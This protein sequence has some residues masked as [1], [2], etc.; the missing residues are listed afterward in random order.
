MRRCGVDAL[1]ATSPVHITYFTDYCCWLDCWFK[2]YMVSPG[3]SSHLT[4]MFA[5]LPLEGESA[6]ILN[7]IFA[8]NASDIWVQD[9]QTFGDT[10]L[11]FSAAAAVRDAEGLRIAG[12]LQSA[13][14]FR[15]AAD[16]LVSTLRSRQLSNAVIGVELEGMRETTLAALRTAFPGAEFR[17]CSNLLR[18]IRMVKSP[19][20][21]LR[22]TRAAEISESASLEAFSMA[23]PGR[24]MSEIAL[25]YRKR[26]AEMGAKEDHFTFSPRG[27]GIAAEPGYTFYGDDTMYMDFGCIYE[28][29]F[30]DT[31][32]TLAL[33]PMPRELR[34]RY[35]ALRASIEAG[36]LELRPGELSSVVRSAM[37]TA[38][39]AHGFDAAF[40]HGHGLGLE[41]REYP[42]LV[43]DN[44]LR[45]QDGCI[46]LPSDLPLE[47]GMVINLEAGMFVP[48]RG[49]LQIE[50]TFVVE[51]ASSRP[52][53]PQLR[54]AAYGHHSLHWGDC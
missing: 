36:V 11:D 12:R 52:L 28:H 10:G 45:V 14:K 43:D 53:I 40:P 38:F 20:E 39:R 21:L 8:A 29:Y 4:E 6:L 22:L 26:V 27:Y 32:A 51:N 41:P 49:S 42:I 3:A 15:S 25:H 19:E 54:D 30:S 17:D 33:C 1:V 23:Q 9:V 46:D 16:A 37:W 7:P 47:E 24:T 50:K 48:E 44:S 35:D 34:Q 18:I 5:V 2:D 13:L 31:G